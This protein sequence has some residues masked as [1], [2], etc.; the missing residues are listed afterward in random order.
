MY[1]K[2]MEVRQ[3]V[4]YILNFVICKY[5]LYLYLE[6]YKKTPRMV[7]DHRRIYTPIYGKEKGGLTT[8]PFGGNIYRNGK[9]L[10]LL[11]VYSQI[12]LWN[13]KKCVKQSFQIRV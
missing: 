7:W 4:S 10:W 11:L 12:Y 1:L 2:G 3:H 9:A 6:R 13:I 5:K 8:L